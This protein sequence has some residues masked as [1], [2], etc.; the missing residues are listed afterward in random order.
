MVTDPSRVLTCATRVS[1]IS[2]SEAP[3]AAPKLVSQSFRRMAISCA[4]TVASARV[5]IGECLCFDTRAQM[6]RGTRTAL[7]AAARLAK[8]DGLRLASAV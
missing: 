3:A 5:P 7:V 2:C 8:A 4:A 1:L 6:R